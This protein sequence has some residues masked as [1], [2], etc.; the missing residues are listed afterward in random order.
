MYTKNP[1]LY[2][3]IPYCF[4]KC[5]YCDF[6]SVATYA[7]QSVPSVYVD[8]LICEIQNLVKEKNISKF[9]S[10]YF[11]GGTPSLLSENQVEKI[12]KVVRSY[13]SVECEVTFELNCDDISPSYLLALYKS[14]VNR[15]SV[16]IQSLNEKTLKCISRRAN[17]FQ[18][19]QAIKTLSAFSAEYPVRAS[20]DFIA[21][22]PY[23]TKED[24]VHD[25]DFAIKNGIEHISLYA[26]TLEENSR[27]FKEIDSGKIP[28]DESNTDEIWIYGRDFLFQN[29]FLQYEISNFCKNG[30][31]S[32]HNSLYWKGLDYFGV[33]AASVSSEYSVDGKN[34]VRTTLTH[35]I[36]AY[37]DFWI[38]TD[39]ADIADIEKISEKEILDEK[40]VMFEYLMT[41][42]RTMDGV[43][44]NVFYKRFGKNV[45]DFLPKNAEKLIE[46]GK[47]IKKEHSYKLS[48]E[49]MLFLNQFLI[50]VLDKFD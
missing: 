9:Y 30:K 22:L 11:G 10:V 32:L 17:S 44:E 20:V 3:H 23:Q 27:L 50:D 29:G 25:L 48:P 2:I 36:K 40:K 8:A 15:F 35:N 38:S 18:T 31:K 41:S 28:Y 39:N 49:E 45:A 34:C 4:S 33:G 7:V 16:G 5:S 19:V 47:L 21:G 37:I 14:G 42:F 43:D 13:I 1:S 24:L 6:F 12:M 26:L 46:Q